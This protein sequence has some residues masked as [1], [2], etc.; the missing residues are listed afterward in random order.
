MKDS[1]IYKGFIGSVHFSAEDD[2]FFGKIEGIND[3]VT[4]EADNVDDLKKEFKN[5]VEDYVDL[6]RR[7]KKDPLKSYKGSLNIR[8]S[9]ETHQMAAQISAVKGETLN[10]YFREIIEKKVKEDHRKK[11]GKTTV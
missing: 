6:C 2:V 5:A 10:Q 3:L 8:I 4:F 7:H 11:L 1:L 9:P